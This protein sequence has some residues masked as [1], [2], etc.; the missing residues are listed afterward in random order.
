MTVAEIIADYRNIGKYADILERSPIAC[1][2]IDA[3][4]SV[5]LRTGRDLDGKDMIQLFATHAP[6]DMKSHKGV[7]SDVLG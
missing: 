7:S 3:I 6:G 4:L 1:K 2:L 5:V